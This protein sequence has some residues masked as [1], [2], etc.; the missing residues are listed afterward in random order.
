MAIEI[1]IGV[2]SHPSLCPGGAGNS[3]VLQRHEIQGNPLAC[4]YR[5]F[6]YMKQTALFIS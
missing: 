6:W 4:L 5:T 1:R 2:L 3:F